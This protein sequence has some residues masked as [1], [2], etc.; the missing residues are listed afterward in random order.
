[1]TIIVPGPSVAPFDQNQLRPEGSFFADYRTGSI[2]ALTG[3]SGV[4]SRSGTQTITTQLG[5]YEIGANLPRLEYR[6]NEL[7][8]VP[9]GSTLQ[10]DHN[11][12]AIFPL[13]MF[14]RVIRTSSTSGVI[15]RIGSSASTPST[16]TLEQNSARY[17]LRFYNN[18]N[19]LAEV[20]INT[21]L[22]LNTPIDII[23]NADLN[24][25]NIVVVT[26]R[27]RTA[28]GPYSFQGALAFNSFVNTEW[29]DTKVHVGSL[30]G[31]SVPGSFIASLAIAYGSNINF[32]DWQ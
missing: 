32:W 21:N 17:R 25:L 13:R 22:P 6:Q 1:M 30:A 19:T 27:W 2:D 12:R 16:L 9:T 28:P 26:I 4:F 24:N 14:A 10:Y 15:C 5:T 3:Q 23:A 11:P 29:S 20:E 7:V 18:V 8:Y 31:S